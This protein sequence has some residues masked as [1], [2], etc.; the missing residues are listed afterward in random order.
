LI[1]RRSQLAIC[2]A[3][4]AGMAA[5]AFAIEYNEFRLNARLDGESLYVAAPNFSF[6]SGKSLER[7]KN[8]ASVAFIAQLTVSTSQNYVVPDALSVARFAVSYDIWGESFSVTKITDHPGQRLSA[9]HLQAAEAEAWCFRNLALRRADLPA[10]RPF[11]VQLDMRVE[12]PRDTAG[13]I[14]E[15][16][17]SLARMIEIFSRPVRDKQA[18]WLLNSGQIRLEDL[19]RKGMHG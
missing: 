14:G 9:S 18:H 4:V 15:G 6:L 5:S 13:M 17:F 2:A 11:Y 12:D 8:G 16:G 1:S 3:L 10:D 7:L 19:L